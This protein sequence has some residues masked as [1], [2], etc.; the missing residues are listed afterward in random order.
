MSADARRAKLT[1]LRVFLK[2]WAILRVV[3][4]LAMSEEETQMGTK[5]VD[6]VLLIFR[7]TSRNHGWSCH[8]REQLIRG[9]LIIYAKA[10]NDTDTNEVNY[11]EA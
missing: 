3:I 2:T 1:A 5:L 9:D 8:T 6:T 10:Q 11:P 4:A 7:S